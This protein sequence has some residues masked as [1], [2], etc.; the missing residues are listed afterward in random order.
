M[1]LLSTLA[2]N[3]NDEFKAV[4]PALNQVAQD[5]VQDYAAWQANPVVKATEAAVTLISPVAAIDVQAAIGAAS[6]V[7]ALWEV[8]GVQPAPAPVVTTPAI[9]SPQTVGVSTV[10][11]TITQNPVQPASLP[12]ATPPNPAT[13]GLVDQSHM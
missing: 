6:L 11:P 13:S 4:L 8:Y 2:A 9:Q 12:V 5:M 1:S 10:L 7:Q 3:I